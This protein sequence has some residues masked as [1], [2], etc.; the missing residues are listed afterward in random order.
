MGSFS[1]LFSTN[2]L[3]LRY[4]AASLPRISRALF[5]GLFS[6][7]LFFINYVA[8]CLAT[9]LKLASVTLFHLTCLFYTT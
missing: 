6:A 9:F 1:G 7:N 5:S 4:V 8:A 2:M 3:I